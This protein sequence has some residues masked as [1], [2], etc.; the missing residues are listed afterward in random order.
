MLSG[1]GE[2]GGVVD[3]AVAKTKLDFS[4]PDFSNSTILHDCRKQQAHSR[5][6]A[7]NSVVNRL[8]RPDPLHEV[9]KQDRPEDCTPCRVMGNSHCPELSIRS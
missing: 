5:M 3:T 4:A 8:D 6:A 9:L 2:L 7:P 1:I